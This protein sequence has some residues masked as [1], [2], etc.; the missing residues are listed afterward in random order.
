MAKARTVTR[1]G[2]APPGGGTQ[3]P[4]GEPGQ[5]SGQPSDAGSGSG[6]GAGETPS[7]GGG[8]STSDDAPVGSG[9]RTIEEAL[10]ALREA[11]AALGEEISREEALLL[12]GL[13][14]E[15]NALRP[16][17]GDLLSGPVA[18]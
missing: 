9:F 16:L 2:D 6:S 5:G 8:S 15:V 14:A 13:A 4:S 17:R 18:R 10:E 11:Q 1:Q 3:Q 7:V 12:L